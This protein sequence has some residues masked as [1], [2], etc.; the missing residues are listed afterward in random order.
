MTEEL[1]KYKAAELE[2]STEDDSEE[3]PVP[4]DAKA[5]DGEEDPMKA[6]AKARGVKPVA[7]ARTSGPSA[8]ARWNQAVD[9]AMAKTGNNKM[10]AVA[11]ANRN[12]PGLREAFLAEANAR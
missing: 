1:A 3:E 2:V 12:H 10:K 5:M 4:P 8:S 7:K 9:A 6:K 11:L